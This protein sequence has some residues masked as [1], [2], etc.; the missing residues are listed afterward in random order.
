[1][2]GKAHA[3]GHLAQVAVAHQHDGIAVLEGQIERLH[4]QLEHLLR[5]RGREDESVRVAVAQ[6]AAGQLDVG[7]LGTDVAE[8]GAAAHDVEEDAGDLGADHVGDPFEHQAE[9]GRRGEGHAAHAG[10][11]TAVHH[12]DRRHLAHRLDEHTIQLRQELGQQLGAFR[13]RCDRIAEEVTAAG[14]QSPDRRGVVPPEDHRL[15]RR[16]RY[17]LV[18]YGH[19]LGCRGGPLAEQLLGIQ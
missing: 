15:E 4:A 8:A 2:V 11:A 14:E 5:R 3:T 9:P 12:V 19:W 18:G 7:L 17:R 13:R 1:M 16:Q 6:A 10:S